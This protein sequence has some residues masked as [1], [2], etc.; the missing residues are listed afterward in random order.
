MSRTDTVCEGQSGGGVGFS[1]LG[2][3]VLRG[4]GIDELMR[5]LGAATAEDQNGAPCYMLGGG[6]PA[7]IPEMMA[8][9]RGQMRALLDGDAARFDRMLGI[10][11]PQRGNPRFLEAV[12]GMF[13]ERYGWAITPENLA[14]TNGGQTA[15]FYLFNLLGGTDRAGGRRR[16]VFPLLPEYI[17]Y[18]EQGLEPGIL[19]GVPARIDDG[20]DFLFKYHVDFDALPTG[21][22]VAAYC[23]SRPTNPTANVM[24]DAEVRRLHALARRHGSLLIL[25]N[26]YGTP[27]PNI[28]FREDATPFWDDGV[29]LTYSL[30][31]LGLP[32]T[33]TGLVIGPP[34]V[35]EAVSRMTSLAGLANGTVGQAL[36]L[37]LIANGE[38]V[39]LCREHVLP[40]YRERRDRALAIFR[41]AFDGL[42]LRVHRAEGALFLWLWFP[43]LPET[44]IGL[45]RLL[46]EEGVLV[47]PGRYF[48]H[49]LDRPWSH[50][51]ECLRV[52]H[53][54][55]IGRLPEAA[56]RMAGVVR[57]VYGGLRP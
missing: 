21:D 26:A 50:A 16:I 49:G 1:A 7:A 56:R 55:D 14:I 33:R 34:E 48:S 47:V 23:V 37:P 38:L 29:V 39:D 45:Y 15:F 5:D 13:R 10:Y 24:S 31:K 25:D 27:F 57:R 17:G 42:P 20:G 32:G 35:A 18:A 36:T 54:H 46:K 19:E 4:S 41:E 30:S 52:N 40:F 51:D 11:D 53:S 44:S 43:E 22:D 3:R 12:A 9:W 2:E 8:V 6:Q 28:V